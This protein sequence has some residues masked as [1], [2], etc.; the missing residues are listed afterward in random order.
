MAILGTALGVVFLLLW[1]MLT[2]GELP[3]TSVR[4]SIADDDAGRLLPLTA[5]D[6]GFARQPL[7]TDV[8]GT[9]AM[10][11][12]EAWPLVLGGA[13]AAPFMAALLFGLHLA[14][15]FLADVLKTEVFTDANAR[16]LSLMGWLLVVAGLAWP[17]L[18][19]GYTVLMV[20][21]ANLE[22]VGL[23]VGLESMG[24]VL[25]GL[26]VLVVAAA[27]RYGVELKRD[28]QLTV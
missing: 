2:G 23:G 20:R 27:W 5:P 26:L 7:L 13:I 16:R 10:K 1:P 22:G 25:P 12:D 21:R 28:Q 24:T 15:G 11:T 18:E 19:F 4:V 14:R 3:E 17:L 6:A 9:L 8:Q